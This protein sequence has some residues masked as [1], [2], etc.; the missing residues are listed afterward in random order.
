MEC[1]FF[2]IL[3]RNYSQKVHYSLHRTLKNFP[4]FWHCVWPLYTF[5]ALV[6][7]V[8]MG[9][10]RENSKEICALKKVT[11]STLAVSSNLTTLSLSL[12]SHWLP[13]MFMWRKWGGNCW[14]VKMFILTPWLFFLNSYVLHSGK[15]IIKNSTISISLKQMKLLCGCR[16]EKKISLLDYVCHTTTEFKVTLRKK[17][18]IS[19]WQSQFSH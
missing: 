16:R 5:R 17:Y 15:F 3:L 11:Q 14:K 4:H 18:K 10:D 9:E 2:F 1:E 12:R 19:F 8:M 13:I 6:G 7:Y